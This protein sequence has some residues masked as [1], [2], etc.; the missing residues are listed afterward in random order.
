MDSRGISK[1][2]TS[3]SSGEPDLSRQ[4]QI[5]FY[6]EASARISAAQSL[7]E[8][9]SSL[10]KDSTRRVLL[11]HPE[12]TGSSR[13]VAACMRDIEYFIKF[14]IYALISGT[15]STLDENLLNGLRETY[16]ALGLS[17]SCAV[18]ALEGIKSNHQLIETEA[19][20][21]NEYIDYI[22]N[23]LT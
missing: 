1:A 14:I 16:H 2:E 20:L 6:R 21:T 8:R 19:R 5:D 22:I 18:T 12:N 4:R 15:T 10:V 3:Y 17:L 9:L 13:Q 23:A 7:E 11:A